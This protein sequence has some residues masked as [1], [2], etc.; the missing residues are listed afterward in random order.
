MGTLAG[1]KVRSLRWGRHGDAI[2]DFDIDHDT[3]TDGDFDYTLAFGANY[4][5]LENV[6]L[7]AEYRKLE[8]EDANDGNH[9]EAGV[10]EFNFRVSVGF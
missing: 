7:M 9:Y 5:I 3:V 10:N 2:V 1:L 4:Q 8:Q 6:T